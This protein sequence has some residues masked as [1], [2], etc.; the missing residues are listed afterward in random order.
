MSSVCLSIAS[1]YYY[2]VIRVIAPW[3]RYCSKQVGDS[4]CVRIV[5]ECITAGFS[6]L[7]QP[8]W[9]HMSCCNLSWYWSLRLTRS[10]WFHVRMSCFVWLA[11][12]FDLVLTN[13]VL[14][15]FFW[16]EVVDPDFP[17]RGL[18]SAEISHCSHE[19]RYNWKRLI[20]VWSLAQ[21][22]GFSSDSLPD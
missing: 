14:F 7:H 13:T 3:R 16:G 11:R 10:V 19:L 22:A 4:E 20:L 12:A 6:V 15:H 1:F 5:W 18:I 8:K 17:F 21:W 2:M 9:V